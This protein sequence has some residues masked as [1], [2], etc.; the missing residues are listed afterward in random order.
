MKKLL[1][2]DDDPHL[3]ESLRVVFGGLYEICTALSAEEAAVLLEQQEIDVMLLDVVLPG[4]NGIDFLRIVREIRPNLPVVMISGASS[5][6]PVM[7]ALELGASDF[8]RKPFDIDELRLIV[9]RALHLSDLR[10]Q[11]AGLERELARRPFVAEPDGRPMKKV[12]EDF[13]RTLIEKA[14]ERAGGIQTRAAEVLGTTRRIL[15]YRIQ[16]LKIP[17]GNQPV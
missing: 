16:K 6:R 15:R 10:N 4:L 1:I 5:I 11:V 9:A 2:V 13:E 7:K 3:L 14:L 17:A 8:I 12:L